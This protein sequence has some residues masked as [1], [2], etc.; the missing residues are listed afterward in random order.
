MAQQGAAPASAPQGAPQIVTVQASRASNTVTLG[1]TVVAYKEVTMTA[2]I[3]GRVDMIAGT[4]GDHFKK[5]DILVAIDDSQLLAQRRQIQ[6]QI[7]AA[8]AQIANAQVQYSREIWSPQSRSITN[9]GGMGMPKM[10]DEMFTT[11]FSQSFMPGNYGGN[12]WVDQRAD[13][14]SR[15]TQLSQAQTQLAAAQAQLEQIDAKLRDARSFAP[16]DGVIVK[17]MV[18]VGDTVQPG[19]PLVE[20]A[21]L[22]YLQVKVDV[23]VRLMANLKK[24]MLVPVKLDVGSVRTEARVAQI[25]PSADPVRHTVTVKF[26][27]PIGTPGGPG[28]YAEVMLPE[29]NLAQGEV[30]PVIPDSAVVWR[31]S[32][33]AVYLAGKD[34]KPE[35]RLV[36]LGDY[37]G[38]NQVTVLSG[39]KVGDRIYAV[40][41]K[42]SSQGWSKGP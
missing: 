27:L 4:E 11:P 5:G 28:M 38:N 35:L 21:D 18:E 31:G 10:F 29:S 26:D 33:P 40:P 34:G 17:K 12:R 39:L 15:G 20:Y 23:P 25:F 7:A 19:Q 37:A 36:R 1:G 13:L 32:L 14:Y 30:V 2:Q 22:T 9:S 42:V 3:P 16:F 41:P 8:Q 24:G 6:A